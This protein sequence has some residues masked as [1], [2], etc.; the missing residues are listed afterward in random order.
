MSTL[1]A[2]RSSRTSVRAAACATRLERLLLNTAAAMTAMVE[3]RMDRR[4]THRAAR[5]TGRTVAAH[6]EARSTTSAALHSGI[7][8]R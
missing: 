2:S 5:R 6:D 8:P 7:R 1:T 3:Q 4:A